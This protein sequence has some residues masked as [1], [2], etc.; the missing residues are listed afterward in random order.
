MSIV[1]KQTK[2]FKLTLA[3]TSTQ[4][5]PLPEET[6]SRVIENVQFYSRESDDI[7][8]K[9][10]KKLLIV[11]KTG[12]G[13][14]SLCNVLS[15]YSFNADL[16]EVSAESRSCTQKTNFRNVFFNGDRMK[17]I[18]ILDTLGFDDLNNDTDTTIISDLV[19]KL[20]INCDYVNLFLIAVNGQ[21]PR[22]NGSL[23]GMLKVKK[24]K[25]LAVN[26]FKAFQNMFPAVRE[27]LGKKKQDAIVEKILLLNFFLSR[28]KNLCFL[29]TFFSKR[30]I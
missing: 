28:E 9:E 24:L 3:S 18:S 25:L 19:V 15:G 23:I 8:K 17:P 10:L 2:P 5:V 22:L 7:K 30:T 20:K 26:T 4:D 14:S 29:L 11:G 16:F 21:D 13:K 12:T 27:F 6:D 1:E